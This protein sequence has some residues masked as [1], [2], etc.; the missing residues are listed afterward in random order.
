MKDLKVL[1]RMIILIMTTSAI[2]LFIG[3]YGVDNLGKVNAG[4]ATMYADRVVPLKQLKQVSDAYAVY[5]VDASHK[6]RNDNMSWNEAI[7]S[8]ENANTIIDENLSAYAETKIEGEELR[9]FNE[10]KKL[11]IAADEAYNEIL[12]ILRQGKDSISHQKLANYTIDQMYDKIDPFTAKLAELI[13]IQLALSKEL[14]DAGTALYDSAMIITYTI[15]IIGIVLAVFL[16]Y[17]ITKSIVKELGGEPLE[18]RKIAEEIA[19]GNLTLEFDNQ[20]KRVGIYGAILELSDQLKDTIVKVVEGA[21]NVTAAS[22]QMNSTSQSMSQGSQEQAASAEEISASMEQMT[23]NIQQ[24]T[25]NALQTEKIAVKVAADM[26]EGSAAVFQ[27]VNSMRKI[28]E[29]ISIIEEIARQTNLLALNAAV[30]AARAGEHGKG[31][32]VVA[33]EVRKLAERSQVAAAEINELSSRSVAIAD[34]SGRLLEQIAPSIQNTAKLVQEIAA[35]SGEQNSGT[36]QI[37]N[38]IQQFNQVIQ[39]NAAGAEEIASS[40]EE[41][42]AQAEVLRK[43]VSFFT[44][45]KKK[46][47]SHRVHGKYRQVIDR[48]FKDKIIP[49]LGVKGKVI[50]GELN[51]N[52]RHDSDYEKF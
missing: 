44:V 28:A 10:A 12:N 13:D 43:T 24:N 2:A 36:N 46:Q 18:I 34:R 22:M 21:E 45:N 51:G 23:S 16:A 8:L 32:A 15:I 29:K 25:D 35:S 52:G 42:S 48:Q 41:L 11:R 5:I 19:R 9:L 50:V 49:A 3:L 31:F 14:H 30:E 26:S 40:S 38:A 33:A 47:S 1:T 39:Q 4:I 17:L 6:A 37:N 7:R 20:R 27:T